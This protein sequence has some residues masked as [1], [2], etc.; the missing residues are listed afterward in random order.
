MAFKAFKNGGGKQL[1]DD[2]CQW[3][4]HANAHCAVERLA[5]FSGEFIQKIIFD[6]TIGSMRE[7]VSAV[8]ARR[9]L[10]I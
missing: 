7:G 6:W 3:A 9:S 5:R 1:T 10:V 4:E 8:R 2:L